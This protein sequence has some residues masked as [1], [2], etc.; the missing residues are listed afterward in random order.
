MDAGAR[1]TCLPGTRVD[2]LNDL[3]DS[4]TD[5]SLPSGRNIIWLRGP[6]GSGKSTILTTVARHFS[7]MQ[8]QGAFLFWDQNDPLNSDPLR[9]IR[10]LA[11]QLAYFNPTF[12]AK[13]ATRIEG[14]HIIT[15]ALDTQFQHLLEEPLTELAAE[16]DLGPIVIVLDALDECGTARMREGLLHTLSEGLVKLPSM[17]RLLIASR[18]EP[19][20]QAALSSLNVD[21]CDVPIGNESTYDVKL[22]FSQRLASNARAFVGHHLPSDWPGEPVIRQ[23]VTLS[24]G[25]FIWASTTIR[26]IESGFP[27][28]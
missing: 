21:V 28:E 16:L 1:A 23:L 7:E 12:A 19:D 5:P 22:L 17:F 27:D 18:D 13:L 8:R 26:F 20:I 11:S 6:A 2:I 9:V 14:S 24:G 15:S 4:L 3:F 10:T 25:L